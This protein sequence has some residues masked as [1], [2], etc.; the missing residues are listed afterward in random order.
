VQTQRHL[1]QAGTTPGE[2]NHAST[3][4]AGTSASPIHGSNF[5]AAP[6]KFQ[7]IISKS[8]L[9]IVISGS[10]INPKT[11]SMLNIRISGVKKMGHRLTATKLYGSIVKIRGWHGLF[12]LHMA[13]A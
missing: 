1:E 8:Y 9:K 10:Y 3:D 2:R 6:A 12:T 4:Q 11:Y 13:P 5:R 7:R